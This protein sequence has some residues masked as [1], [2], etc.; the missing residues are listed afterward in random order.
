MKKGNTWTADLPLFSSE[1]PIW[2]YA[3]IRY[4]LDDP[5]TG[6][7]YY[8]RIYTVENF[9]ISSPIQVATSE[10]LKAAGVK[11][12]LKQSLVIETFEAD[13]KKD[14]FVYK[15]KKWNL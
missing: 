7:E 5:M 2:A 13:W 15:P 10:Q 3:N 1:K 8:Y 12:T 4:Q 14:W 9:N 6:A 11:S